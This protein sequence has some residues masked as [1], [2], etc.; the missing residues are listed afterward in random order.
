MTYATAMTM[1]S[2]EYAFKEHWLYVYL[3]LE[4]QSTVD[5]FMAVRILS[6]TGLLYQDLIRGQS[7]YQDRLPPVFPIV[8]YNGEP[9]WKAAV[10]LSEL[11]HPAPQEL[12]TYQPNN[13]T[14]CWMK[15]HTRIVPSLAGVR[16]LV[17]AVFR[18]EKT[19]AVPK[20]SSLS[21]RPCWTGSKARNRPACAG[22]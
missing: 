20:T 1:S 15:G 18:L 19:A 14:C 13:A 21:S 9:R 6:Y 10:D 3:L 2:G 22:L 12:Q 8:L 4:F 7:L 17:A 11:I 16:N 5:R